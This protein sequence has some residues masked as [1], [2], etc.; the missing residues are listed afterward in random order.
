MTGGGVGAAAVSGLPEMRV[1]PARK[2]A[3]MLVMEYMVTLYLFEI[4]VLSLFLFNVYE[5]LSG[6]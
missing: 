1:T 2:S 5:S 3:A 6:Q 4:C